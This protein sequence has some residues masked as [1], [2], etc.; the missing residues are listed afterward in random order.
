MWCEEPFEDAVVACL[1]IA[2]PP[3]LR[4]VDLQVPLGVGQVRVFRDVYRVLI[5]F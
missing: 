4:L 1:D 3:E 5:T 2:L